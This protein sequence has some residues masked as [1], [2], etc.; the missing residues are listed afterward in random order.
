MEI[1]GIING[2]WPFP[3]NTLYIHASI[4]TQRLEQLTEIGMHVQLTNWSDERTLYMYM[5]MHQYSFPPTRHCWFGCV[6]V[7]EPCWL[8][9]LYISAWNTAPITAFHDCFVQ[10]SPYVLMSCFFLQSVIDVT[11]P[12]L[13]PQSIQLPTI[14]SLDILIWLQVTTG[15]VKLY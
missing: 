2:I 14:P 10:A 13:W 7:S 5:H 6:P 15:T 9:W 4:Q 12:T 8:S 3:V 1:A 11:V